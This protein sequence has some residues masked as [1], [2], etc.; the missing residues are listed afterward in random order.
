MLHFLLKQRFIDQIER[1]KVHVI[2]DSTSMFT[3][4]TK[5]FGRCYFNEDGDQVSLS[6]CPISMF[7]ITTSASTSALCQKYFL[8]S[9]N[10]R[11]LLDGDEICNQ[12]IPK[13][14]FRVDI[15]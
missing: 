10:A 7:Y 14:H 2:A 13:I 6:D 3:N 12:I 8:L 9:E 1:S 4:R 15:V 5:N 11:P